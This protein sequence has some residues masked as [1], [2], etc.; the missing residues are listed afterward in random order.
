MLLLGYEKRGERKEGMRMMGGK[1]RSTQKYLARGKE[2]G[3]SLNVPKALANKISQKH[4]EKN[5]IMTTNVW[6]QHSSI[7]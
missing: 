4:H 3:I 2:Q 6:L 1:R 5:Q 7:N